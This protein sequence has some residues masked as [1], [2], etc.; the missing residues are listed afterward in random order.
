MRLKTFAV[1]LVLVSLLPATALQAGEPFCRILGCPVPDCIG[2]WCCDDYQA[3]CLPCVKVPF[4]FGCDDYCRKSLPRVCAPLC[5]SCDDYCKKCP[6]P[7]C[8]P[9]LLATLRCVPQRASCGCNVCATEGCDQATVTGKVASEP[10]V[11]TARVVNE[12]ISVAAAAKAAEPLRD[13]DTQGTPDAQDNLDAQ[14]NPKP[15]FIELF[16]R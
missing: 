10:L 2:K 8:R 13:L 11:T 5:F 15:V 12:A 16:R 6:P 3:K 7:V 1:A 4:C 9:P 14:D